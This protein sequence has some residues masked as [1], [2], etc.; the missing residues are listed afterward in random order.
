MQTSDNSL[1]LGGF[2]MALPK[3][4]DKHKVMAVILYDEFGYPQ[5]EIANLM[6]VSPSTISSWIALG[7][8]MVS[9]E[10][11]KREVVTIREE[12]NKLGY[13]PVKNLN[14]DILNITY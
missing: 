1:R 4:E 13:N 11:L 14:S 3:G 8:L 2:I 10:L 7:R 9:N 5:V 12:L 6:K